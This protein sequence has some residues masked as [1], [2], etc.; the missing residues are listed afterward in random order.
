MQIKEEMLQGPSNFVYRFD[1]QKSG[2]IFIITLILLS[3]WSGSQRCDA[4]VIGLKDSQAIQN[5]ESVA[6]PQNL[7]FLSL[8]FDHHLDDHNFSDVHSCSFGCPFPE[9]TKFDISFAWVGVPIIVISEPTLYFE[10]LE[11]PS[12]PPLV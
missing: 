5:S 6:T 3:L 7:S 9:A 1:V 10:S 2:A 4:S 12:R 11:P 8:Q